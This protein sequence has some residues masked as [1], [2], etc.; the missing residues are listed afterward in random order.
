M[1]VHK[2]AVRPGRVATAGC[3]VL[4]LAASAI[5]V[6]LSSSVA[7]AQGAEQAPG[8]AW[9]PFKAHRRVVDDTGQVTAGTFYRSSD[10]ST[11]IEGTTQD[12]KL[13]IQIRDLPRSTIYNWTS[14]EGW[15]T[16]AFTLHPC[17]F[18]PMPCSFD[19]RSGTAVTTQYSDSKWRQLGFVPVPYAVEGLEG[20]R[21]LLQGG[22]YEGSF[23]L[24]AP[25]LDMFNVIRHTCHRLTENCRSVR[26]SDIQIGEQDSELF[27]PFTTPGP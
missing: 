9:I 2:I 22:G 6:G 5:L 24:A 26:H 17:G 4:C 10:G 12:G 18:I 23:V 1:L 14:E 19:R 7:W 21:L 16:Y 25:E 13:S 27:Q 3:I 8:G 11:R 20:L 15:F